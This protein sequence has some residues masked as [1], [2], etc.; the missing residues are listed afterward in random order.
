MAAVDAYMSSTRN[1]VFIEYASPR[2]LLCSRCLSLPVVCAHR[3]APRRYVLLGPDF[4]CLESHAHELGQL[5][6]DRDVVV[7]II[8][9]NPVLSPD[10]EFRAP[11]PGAAAAFQRILKQY[12][13]ACTVR[14]EKGQDVAAACGQ[15]VLQQQ[16]K[17]HEACDCYVGVVRRDF[18]L[19]G[20][21][22]NAVRDVE[23]IV[24]EDKRRHRV[25][26]K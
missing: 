18:A 20:L 2:R 12:G 6:R 11:P 19:Q 3:D 25:S 21:Q 4:N 13:L 23:D 26:C 14:Q 22:S 5:L 8:P 10:F 7:N 17:L 16:V 15:L 24:N 9:W 1:R